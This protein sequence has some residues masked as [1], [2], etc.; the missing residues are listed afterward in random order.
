MTYR[1]EKNPYK[2]SIASLQT[3][4]SEL[5]EINFQVFFFRLTERN[6]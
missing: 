1:T 3:R 4:P 2:N 6:A 5:Y